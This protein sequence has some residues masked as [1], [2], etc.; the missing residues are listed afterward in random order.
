[1]CFSY[2][3]W[4]TSP[5]LITKMLDSNLGMP[6]LPDP[7]M[8]LDNS[9]YNTNI[10]S[11]RYN[12]SPFRLELNNYTLHKIIMVQHGTNC[13]YFWP[14][15]VNT[16][17]YSSLWL[18]CTHT[19]FYLLLFPPIYCHHRMYEKIW[20]LIIRKHRFHHCLIDAH[21]QSLRGHAMQTD[22]NK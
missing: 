19:D 4:I 20:M 9:R 18:I 21:T 22:S 10:C 1:M 11:T 3:L 17:A 7:L 2:F 5:K 13:M 8:M 6:S 16:S 12:N 14:T 15:E